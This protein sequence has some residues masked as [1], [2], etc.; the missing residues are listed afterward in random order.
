MTT[1]RMQKVI[2]DVVRILQEEKGDLRYEITLPEIGALLKSKLEQHFKDWPGTG[3]PFVSGAAGW[4]VAA[5]RT[6]TPS[7]S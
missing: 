7:R 5:A 2:S 4:P 1:R 3:S 6:P